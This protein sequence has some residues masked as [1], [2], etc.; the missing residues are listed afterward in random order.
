MQSDKNITLFQTMLES[1]FISVSITIKDK[2]S[3]ISD[4]L[5]TTLDCL[6]KDACPP[7]SQDDNE[8]KENIE[9][10]NQLI[11]PGKQNT[12]EEIQNK[13]QSSSDEGNYIFM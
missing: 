7:N 11:E 2:K 13:E 3:A 4:I 1:S 10:N 8:S 5:M 6:K 12:D 9:D